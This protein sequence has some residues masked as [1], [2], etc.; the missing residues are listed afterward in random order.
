IDQMVVFC[1]NSRLIQRYRD[2]IAHAPERAWNYYRL[3]QTAEATGQEGLALES[4]EQALRRGR[5]S[6]TIHCVLL[7]D[8]ARDHYYR[9]LMKLGRKAR[10]GRDFAQAAERFEAAGGAARTDRERLAAR[11]IL[12]EVQ[13]DWGRP[14]GAVVT[15]QQLLFDDRLR[16]LNI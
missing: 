4:L 16:P 8:G 12:A 6:E 13:L 5:P 10:S 15:L 7:R 9:L 11:L 14:Q 1:Q 3:A 2:E